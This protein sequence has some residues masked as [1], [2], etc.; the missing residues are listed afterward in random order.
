MASNALRVLGVAYR[1]LT[2][3]PESPQRRRS[4]EG[5]HIRRT[6]RHDRSGASGSGRGGQGGER[7]R[8]PQRHGDR[9]LQGHRRGDRARDRL[10]DQGRP[11]A[12]RPGDREA[13]RRGAGG[14]DRQAAGVLPGFAA[15]Q[16]ANRRC[17][18][19]ARP[20]RGDDGRRRQRRAGAEAREHRRRHGHHRYRRD[21]ADGGHG[22]HRRQLRQHRRGDRAGADHLLQHPQVRLLPAGLQRRRDPDHLRRDAAGIADSAA[23]GPPAVAEPGERRGARPRPGHGEGRSAT[24]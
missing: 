5:P 22:P 12:D 18:E 19:G 16:D 4:R 9:R 15:A 14:R 13:E 17:P 11:G 21:Q 23:P 20:R 8:T 2:E 1:P 10:A 6:A 7:R 3:V 24:S